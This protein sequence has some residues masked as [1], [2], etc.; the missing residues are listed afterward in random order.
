MKHNEIILDA[1]QFKE[2]CSILDDGMQNNPG[3]PKSA[4]PATW[5]VFSDGGVSLTLAGKAIQTF[6]FKLKDYQG[7]E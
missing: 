3:I 5:Q 2:L 4:D 1:R 6:E 7:D